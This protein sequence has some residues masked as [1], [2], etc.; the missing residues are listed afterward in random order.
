MIPPVAPLPFAETAPAAPRARPAEGEPP[1]RAVARAFEAVF[2]AEMLGHAG[3]GAGR[4]GPGGGGVGEAA[5]SSLLA[6]EWAEGLA[7][8]GGIGLADHIERALAAR[9][10]GD[11]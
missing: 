8:R 6:R 10:G 7:A 5:F 9:G 2:L 1:L 11:A 3:L 4:E